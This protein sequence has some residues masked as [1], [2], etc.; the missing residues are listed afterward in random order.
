MILEI[1]NNELFKSHL[2]YIHLLHFKL[3]FVLFFFSALLNVHFIRSIT[4]F[5]IYLWICVSNNIV[6]LHWSFYCF[7]SGVSCATFYPYQVSRSIGDAYLKKPEFS[8]D[9]SFPK[10]HLSEPLHRPVLRA[11]PSICTRIL[12]PNDKFLIFASDGLWEHLSNQEAVE[13][14][15]NNPRVVSLSPLISYGWLKHYFWSFPHIYIYY[16]YIYICFNLL[17]YY[18]E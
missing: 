2:G 18:R 14:V 16:I 7:N 15:Y 3:F 11:D 8:L 17:P 5:L 6:Y 13:I 1:I 4:W 12:Q 9:P 10:F